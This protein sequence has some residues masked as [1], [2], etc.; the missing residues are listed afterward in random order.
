[1]IRFNNLFDDNNEQ[2]EYIEK[3]SKYKI[4]WVDKYRPKTLDDIVQQDEII[5]FLKKSLLTGNMPHL[6][7]HG[8]PGSGKTSAILAIAN[9][10]YGPIKFSERVILSLPKIKKPSEIS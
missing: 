3:K 9:Q 5:N 1:M 7:F 8:P 6:L 4:P 2:I 10:L